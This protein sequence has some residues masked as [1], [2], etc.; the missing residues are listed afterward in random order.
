MAVMSNDRK[1]HAQL[2]VQERTGRDVPE[3]LRELYVDKR[4][5][6]MEIARAL[7]VS[8]ITVGKWLRE[9]ELT[10]PK[11]EVSL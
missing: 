6:Q 2:R 10:R 1:S 11:R 3:L 9:L 8:R 7:D 5:S 4:H